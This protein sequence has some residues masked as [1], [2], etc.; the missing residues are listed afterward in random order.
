MGMGTQAGSRDEHPW[1]FQKTGLQD[2]E[3]PGSHPVTLWP[4]ASHLALS[5]GFSIYKTGQETRASSRGWA[6]PCSAGT[7]V[8]PCGWPQTT[9]P[10]GSGE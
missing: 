3:S 10:Q 1:H 4:G 2:Q 5:H 9:R 8:T 6:L 7:S